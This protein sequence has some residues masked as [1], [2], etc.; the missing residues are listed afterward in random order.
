MFTYYLDGTRI[1]DTDNNIY[2][3]SEHGHNNFIWVSLHSRHSASWFEKWT[4]PNGMIHPL[5]DILWKI[6][7]WG[8]HPNQSWALPCLSR[9]WWAWCLNWALEHVENTEVGN[10]WAKALWLAA[11]HTY[12][13][14]PKTIWCINYQR[15]NQRALKGETKETASPE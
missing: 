5:Q 15:H 1:K 6:S 3:R 9:S 2:K 11:E 10:Q 12:E 14:P 8:R 13:I 4:W 7:V